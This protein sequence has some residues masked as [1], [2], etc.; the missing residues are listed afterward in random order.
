MWQLREQVLREKEAKKSGSQKVT[1][2]ASSSRSQ[3]PAAKDGLAPIYV[4][5]GKE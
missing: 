4:G 1:A 5:F 3:L 2:A